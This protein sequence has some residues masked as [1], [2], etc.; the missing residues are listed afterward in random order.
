MA[1]DEEIGQTDVNRAPRILLELD[2]T[3]DPVWI[4][5][6]TQHR[7]ILQLLQSSSDTSIARIKGKARINFSGLKP[8]GWQL[9]DFPFITVAMESSNQTSLTDRMIAQDLK[10]CVASLDDFDGE[11]VRGPSNSLTWFPFLR[12]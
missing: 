11:S 5:F 12:S 3:D 1:A 7:H 8:V 2:P 4:F 9:A 10:S 6:D